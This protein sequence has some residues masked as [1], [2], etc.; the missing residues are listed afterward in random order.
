MTTYLGHTFQSANI[1][2]FF[3]KNDLKL[4]FFKKTALNSI[5]KCDKS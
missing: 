2:I 3:K 5:Q 4:V 1:Q